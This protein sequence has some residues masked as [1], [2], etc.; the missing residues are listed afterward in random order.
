M[1]KIVLLL[2]L[3]MLASCTTSIEMPL[4]YCQAADDCAPASCCHP[5]N[6]V[7]KEYAPDCSETICTMVCLGPQ[8]CNAG[9]AECINNKCI[10][11]SN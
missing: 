1:E 5:D 2:G 9:H 11:F 3:L 7:N 4:D 10:I 6:L 8:D